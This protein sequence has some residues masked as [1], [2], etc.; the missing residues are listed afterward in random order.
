MLPQ[1]ALADVVNA[2]SDAVVGMGPIEFLLK[3]PE[4]TERHAE[5]A[6]PT[7]PPGSE[8]IDDE[9]HNRSHEQ[10]EDNRQKE[11][12][13]PPPQGE[14]TVVGHVP[15]LQ[16]CGPTITA[17]AKRLSRAD[18]CSLLT[19]QVS[20]ARFLPFTA[21][22]RGAERSRAPRE[23]SGS[24]ASTQGDVASNRRPGAPRCARSHGG[25]PPLPLKQTVRHPLDPPTRLLMR[26]PRRA[27]PTRRGTWERIS[28]R[29]EKSTSGGFRLRCA[30][31]QRS[32]VTTEGA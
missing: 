17:A 20:S 5:Q 29:P 32:R 2:V 7:A 28:A 24:R 16:V 22:E 4:V 8:W 14:P 3:D 18:N 30:P 25:P 31:L 23:P 1:S 10:G 27:R 6:G 19:R 21:P 13:H 26:T 11:V 12:L 9:Q 15:P